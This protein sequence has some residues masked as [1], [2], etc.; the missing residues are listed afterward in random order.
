MQDCGHFDVLVVGGGPAGIGAGIAAA[1][2]GANTLVLEK[3]AFLG[4]VASW[5]MQINQMLPLGKSRGPV[6]DLIVEKL[7]V[8]GDDALVIDTHRLRCNVE[9][10]KVALM[11]ALDESGCDF[12][13]HSGVV[14]TITEGE[15]VTGVVVGSRSGFVKLQAKVTVDASGDADVTHCAGGETLKRN[16]EGSPMT[17]YFLI[18]PLEARKAYKWLPWTQSPEEGW[19]VVYQ[20]GKE[21]YPLLPERLE[22]LL[23]SGRCIS[24]DHYA[25]HAGKCMGNCMATG[26]AAGVAAALAARKGVMPRELTVTEI[27]SHLVADGVPLYDWPEKNID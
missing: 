15:R 19:P 20:R 4:G 22:G 27:Q 3:H 13:L 11:D 17:L 6:H 2:A 7:K 18:A 9:Y 14:D 16:E 1:R 26:Q 12:L 21:T 10:L 5:G 24:A 8:Y 25:H 23:A